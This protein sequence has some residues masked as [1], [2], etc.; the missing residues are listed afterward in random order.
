MFDLLSKD[1]NY[2]NTENLA[3]IL[4]WY[5]SVFKTGDSDAL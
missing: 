1:A 4:Q 2:V 3:G 5:I